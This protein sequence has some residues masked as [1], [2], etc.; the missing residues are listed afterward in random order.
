MNKP[1][2]RR[3]MAV[4]SATFLPRPIFVKHSSRTLRAVHQGQVRVC[5][6]KQTSNPDPSGAAPSETVP[7]N[8]KS[9]LEGACWESTFSS[10]LVQAA[11]S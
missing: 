1:R 11:V 8:E 2:A 3:G 10:P 5:A 7:A 4:W 6:N 9:R